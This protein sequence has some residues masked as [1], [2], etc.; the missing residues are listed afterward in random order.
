MTLIY[1]EI[2]GTVTRI[3]AVEADEGF[4]HLPAGAMD[5][6]FKKGYHLYKGDNGEYYLADI[7]GFSVITEDKEIGIMDDY[8][9]N[10]ADQ[11]IFVVKCNDGT[12]KYI[13]D[14]EEF[15]KKVDLDEQ[16]IYVEL[17]KGM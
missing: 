1:N 11:T 5:A 7:I 2:D 3:N 17:I 14:M 6:C 13:P 12:V 4:L 8:F 10:A 15:V 16:K 9:E